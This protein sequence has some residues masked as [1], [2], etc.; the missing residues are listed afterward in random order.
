[1]LYFFSKRNPNAA[2]AFKSNDVSAIQNSAFVASKPTVFV[3]HGWQAN[4]NSEISA[5]I[6][7]AILSTADVNVF[8]VDWSFY[9]RQLY[10]TAQAAVQPV[11]RYVAAF[12]QLLQGKG[13]N[14]GNVKMVGHS[15][16]AHVAGN[17]GTALGGKVN[18][19][20]GLDPAGPLF[21]AFNKKK[22]L[23]TSDAQ[24]VEVRDN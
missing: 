11:G 17:A 18:T 16:G 1:M 21:T 3:I 4:H 23:S 13:L 15:L 12:V 5:K 8:L 14:V 24:F 10:I 22:R 9:A 7:D 20:T 2:F 6:K 19:I